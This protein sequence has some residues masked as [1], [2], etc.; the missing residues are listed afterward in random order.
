MGM[1]VIVKDWVVFQDK[2]EMGQSQSQA[3]SWRQTSVCLSTNT[4]R[5][6]HLSAGQ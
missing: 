6:I 2:K 5:L 1:L 3:N 4:G